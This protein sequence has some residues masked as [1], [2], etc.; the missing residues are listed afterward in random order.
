MKLLIRNCVKDP[1]YKELRKAGTPVFK[2]VILGEVLAPG[3]IRKVLAS[4]FNNVELLNLDSLVKSGSCSVVD[5]S[6]GDLSDLSSVFSYLGFDQSEVVADEPA[7]ELGPDEDTQSVEEPEIIEEVSEEEDPSA[8]IEEVIEEE[9]TIYT[10]SEL[11]ELRNADLRDMI[12]DM[13]PE[14]P[15]ANKSKKKLIAL[16]LEIQ[17]G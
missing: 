14:A 7:D 4:K 17:N 3:A 1:K 15:V 13:D 6:K 5:L 8:E 12:L 9:S 16:L 11:L 10:E 2:P